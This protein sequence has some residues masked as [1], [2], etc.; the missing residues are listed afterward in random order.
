M[1]SLRRLLYAELPDMETAN[2][3]SEH[4]DEVHD[5]SMDLREGTRHPLAAAVCVE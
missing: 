4:V 5:L 1:L 3:E 2:R